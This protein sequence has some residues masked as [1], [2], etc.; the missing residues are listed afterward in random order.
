M[1][2]S[3]ASYLASSVVARRHAYSGNDNQRVVDLRSPALRGATTSIGATERTARMSEPE[4]G[5]GQLP[6]NCRECLARLSRGL[7][8]DC[9]PEL[10]SVIASHKSGD[11]E[12][13]AG[14]DLFQSRRDLRFDL[15][16]NSGLGYSLQHFWKTDDDR[17]CIS[18]CPALYSV[19]TP[20][21]GRMMTY[22]AQALTNTTV[23]AVPHKALLSVAKQRP[24]FGLRLAWIVARDYSLALDRLTSLGRHSARERVAHLLLELFIRYRAQWPGSQIEEIEDLP[25]TQE[26]VGD[27]TGLTF[28]HVNRVLRDLRKDG[29]VEFRYRTASGSWI[30][31]NWSTRR[32][33]TLSW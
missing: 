32:Q 25:L 9:G 15:Q 7:C 16:C 17:F 21:I 33:L 22:G 14:Q 28:V 10:L 1:I 19:T 24:E 6:L 13:K 31:T 27:A 26:D 20:P 3:A 2:P 30:R 11:R 18:R 5:S 12:F 8:A 23:C 29:I 4:N